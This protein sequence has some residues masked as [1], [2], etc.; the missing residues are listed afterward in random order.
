MT[1]LFV[2]ESDF[3]E[4]LEANNFWIYSSYK[5]DPWNERSEKDFEEGMMHLQEAMIRDNITNRA[6]IIEHFMQSKKV[7]SQTV[8]K[9][10][11]PSVPQTAP[12]GDYNFQAIEQI[13]DNI[14]KEISSNLRINFLKQPKIIA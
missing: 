1:T 6:Q 8:N 2:G 9:T 4:W 10:V 5:D 13:L 11:I 7:A 12:Q 14:G 3:R